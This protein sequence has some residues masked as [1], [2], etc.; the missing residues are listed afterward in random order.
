MSTL[1][2]KSL[3]MLSCS[4][5]KWIVHYNDNVKGTKDYLQSKLAYSINT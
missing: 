5:S 1:N 2:N 4:P 3:L